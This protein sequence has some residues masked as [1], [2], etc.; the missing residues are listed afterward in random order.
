M[1]ST[2]RRY[3]HIPL[4]VVTLVL[5][6]VYLFVPYPGDTVH[7]V[8][9]VLLLLSAAAGCLSAVLDRAKRREE[10]D[11]AALGRQILEHIEQVVWVERVEPTREVIYVNSAYEALFGMPRSTAS[12]APESWLHLVHSEDRE[13]VLDAARNLGE[14]GRTLE[15]RLY[16]PGGDERWVQAR[17]FR[18]CRGERRGTL[19]A[20]VAED[21]TDL[22]SAIA[23]VRRNRAQLIQ[24]EKLASLGTLVAGIGHEINNPNH[25]IMSTAAILEEA[26]RDLATML[27]EYVDEYGEFTVAGTGYYDFA[28]TMPLYLEGL[29]RASERIRDIVS[30]LRDFARQDVYDLNGLVE[31]NEMVEGAV[32]LMK[33]HIQKHTSRFGLYLGES[34]PAVRGNLP[35]LQQVVVN[36]LQNACDALSSERGAV[37]VRTDYSE[38]TDEVRVTIRDEGGGIA[39]EEIERVLDPFYTTRRTS[40]GMGLGLSVSQGIIDDHHGRLRIESE[41]DRGTTV[42]ICL[43]ADHGG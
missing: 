32:S 6:G 30:H 22:K 33:S 35:R 14:E 21:I 42:T 31:V 27:S 37:E 9:G 41:I 13:E 5:A 20:G 18:L 43:P 23:S 17:L 24:A 28:E 40:G 25:T 16:P 8:L 10:R 26:W 29:T 2:R 19:V 1:I 38:S 7:T 39:D 11:A 4:A 15:Y 12:Q 3:P 36:I 34:L